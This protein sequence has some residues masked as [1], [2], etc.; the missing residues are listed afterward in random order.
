MEQ[1]EVERAQREAM[2]LQELEPRHPRAGPGAAGASRRVRRGASVL[3]LQ[4]VVGLVPPGRSGK[5]KAGPRPGGPTHVRTCPRRTCR[6]IPAPFPSARNLTQ[7]RFAHQGDDKLP[8][9]PIAKVTA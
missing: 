1:C 7:H 6:A 5:R 4:A 3:P 9:P 2:E 8:C